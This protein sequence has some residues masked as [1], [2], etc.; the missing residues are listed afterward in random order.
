MISQT[1][2]R[3]EHNGKVMPPL[4]FIFSSNSLP[5]IQTRMTSHLSEKSE[6]KG[7]QGF[8]SLKRSGDVSLNSS[9]TLT[10]KVSTVP[11]GDGFGSSVLTG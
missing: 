6:S 7:S 1:F 3:N 9:V 11:G 4:L 10:V 2:L 8:S 5:Y